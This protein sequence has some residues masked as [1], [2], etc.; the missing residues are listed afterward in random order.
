MQPRV[1]RVP[2]SLVQGVERS[3]QRPV[4][5]HA[6][7]GGGGGPG[8]SP[9]GG[10]GGGPRLGEEEKRRVDVVRGG[11]APERRSEQRLGRRWSDFFRTEIVYYK[12]KSTTF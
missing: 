1:V 5:W 12:E 9:G 4:V 6:L 3:Q 8:G 11:A 2:V 7:N 10:G